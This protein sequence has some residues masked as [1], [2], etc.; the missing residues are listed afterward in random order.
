MQVLEGIDFNEV[1]IDIILVEQVNENLMGIVESDVAEL[2]HK[3][4]YVPTQKMHRTVV[5]EKISIA[6]DDYFT[7]AI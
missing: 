2:L 3:H 5:Y 7:N 6:T 4:G 1:V